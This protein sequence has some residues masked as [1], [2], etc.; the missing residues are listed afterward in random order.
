VAHV[1]T[2][3]QK[4]WIQMFSRNHPFD[5]DY[6]ENW[7]TID[8]HLP[9]VVTKITKPLIKKEDSQVHISLLGSKKYDKYDCIR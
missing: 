6:V 1:S 4:A 7:S 9:L 3:D 8:E 2:C 5:K